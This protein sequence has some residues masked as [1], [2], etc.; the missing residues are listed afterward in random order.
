MVYRLSICVFG[1]KIF[2]WS[3]VLERD[4]V[5]TYKW[6]FSPTYFKFCWISHFNIRLRVRMKTLGLQLSISVHF[7]ICHLIFLPSGDTVCYPDIMARFIQQWTCMESS[8]GCRRGIINFPAGYIF[9]F[10]INCNRKPKS[11]HRRGRKTLLCKHREPC[12]VPLNPSCYFFHETFLYCHSLI[13]H[14]M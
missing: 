13:G 6:T 5:E 2:Q 10:H 3:I 4:S 7:F 14:L 1:C 9:L 12:S 11:R 8:S